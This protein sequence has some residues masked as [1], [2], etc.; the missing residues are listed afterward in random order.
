MSKFDSNLLLLLLPSSFIVTD[1]ILT[2]M[3]YRWKQIGITIV[4]NNSAYVEDFNPKHVPDS[5]GPGLRQRQDEANPPQ[6]QGQ[7]S[8][9]S[10]IRHNQSN[11]V[12]TRSPSIGSN[13]VATISSPGSPSRSKKSTADQDQRCSSLDP[14]YND[15]G[16]R[17]RSRSY[18]HSNSNSSQENVRGRS[19]SRDS[20]S[21]SRSQV[22]SRSGR[23]S[24][25]SFRTASK[26][27]PR[28]QSRDRSIISNRDQ[29]RSSSISRSRRILS[30]QTNSPIPLNAET[31]SRSLAMLSSN[32]SS[33]RRGPIDGDSEGRAEEKNDG[34]VEV[35]DEGFDEDLKIRD[36]KGEG[37]KEMASV[38]VGSQEEDR[39]K[40]SFNL[41]NNRILKSQESQ[42]TPSSKEEH[43]VSNSNDPG[44]S[45][46]H[47][48]K[49][50]AGIPIS[51]KKIFGRKG[52]H[53]HEKLIPITILSPSQSDVSSGMSIQVDFPK[54]SENSNLKSLLGIAFHPTKFLIRARQGERNLIIQNLELKP[55][56]RYSIPLPRVDS[57]SPA[58]IDICLEVYSDRYRPG[59]IRRD[60]RILPEM[61]FKDGTILPS[62]DG[63]SLCSSYD[64]IVD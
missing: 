1:L 60:S 43:T 10:F 16:F 19:R 30:R 36:E 9:S 49:P 39:E 14:Y 6:P 59:E 56:P 62:R 51:S 24:S 44:R 64:S 23:S 31:L 37:E 15:A 40:V 22:S 50:A 26:D 2:K 46:N 21:R 25:R 55:I 57:T 7:D 38:S 32:A 17:A 29:S 41:E 48:L 4:A 54:F 53:N 42:E 35:D 58:F 20:R 45:A 63:E 34:L 47:Q 13:L 27:R 12:L 3:G 18:S 28:S 33:P 61:R 5:S 11:Q 52:N 8:D